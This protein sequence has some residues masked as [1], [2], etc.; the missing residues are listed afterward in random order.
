MSHEIRTPMNAILGMTRMV[1]ETEL[2]IEQRRKL[3]TVQKSSEVLLTLINDILDFEKI[4]AGRLELVSRP[5]QLP[6]VLESVI[7]LLGPGA[8]EKGLALT[9]SLEGE[10]GDRV[11][12]ADDIRLRQ[13]LFNLVGNGIKFTASGGVEI[14]CRCL[15]SR[16]DGALLEF[17]VRDS[18]IGIDKIHQAR[19]FESFCQGDSSVSMSHGGSGLGLT[20]T[21]KLLALMDGQI[22]VDSQLG[23]GSVF[24]V[25]LFLPYNTE[26]AGDGATASHLAAGRA[27]NIPSLRILVVD[28]V[29]PNRDLARMILEQ[30]GHAVDEAVNGLEA[31]AALAAMDYDMVLLDVQMPVVDGFQAIYHIR[32]AEQGHG[33]D[34]AYEYAD[35]LEEMCRRILK[36]HTP[37]IALTAHARETDRERCLQAGMDSY[38]SKPFNAPEMLRQIA[39][40]YNRKTEK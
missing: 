38:L 31:M 4:E 28:D 39:E 5:F 2:T 6:E 9:F 1:L 20:I 29:E 23:E 10:G 21:R 7:G 13:V 27:E 15:E 22:S 12:Y 25:S 18:G 11:F 19:I 16:K 26:D 34:P 37:V 33:Y 32:R 24:T 30:A 17:K 3:E 40:L 35:I 36:R 8:A 14:Q